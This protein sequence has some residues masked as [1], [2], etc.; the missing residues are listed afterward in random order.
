MKK[1]LTIMLSSILGLNVFAQCPAG[2]VEVT[3]DVNTDAWG[4]EVYWEL[5]PSGN[6]CGNGTIF[7]GGNS[8][9]GCSGGGLQSANAGSGYA[10]SAVI[11]EGPGV[12]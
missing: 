7:S 3:I 4:Y 8:F 2:E 6:G 11:N 12:S 1:L 5:V 10:N 9:V